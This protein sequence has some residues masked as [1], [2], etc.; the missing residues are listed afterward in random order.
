MGK[1]HPIVKAVG[2]NDPVTI[3]AQAVLNREL[4][5][6]NMGINQDALLT[7]KAQLCER[8]DR[9]AGEASH[10]TLARIADEIDNIR[11]T[12]TS[13]GIDSVADLAHALE[14]AMAQ[15]GSMVAIHSYLE[16]MRAATECDRVDHAA[17]STFMASVNQRL[18]G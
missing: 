6:I 2:V 14:S 7:V 1:K 4:G 5:G 18:Y 8:I 16:A 15:S 17:A 10:M 12:A 3:R 11:R 13:Y 9:I